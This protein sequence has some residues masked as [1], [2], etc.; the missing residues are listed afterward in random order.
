MRNHRLAT[1][2]VAAAM[3]TASSLAVASPAHAGIAIFELENV[4]IHECLQ[5]TGGSSGLGV[6]IA[7]YPCDGS[8]AQQWTISGIHLVNRSSGLCLD[9]RGGAVEYTAVEQWTC[10]WISNENWNFGTGEELVSGVSNTYSYCVDTV[11]NAIYVGTFLDRCEN[12]PWQWWA[13]LRPAA[14][15]G[16]RAPS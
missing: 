7:T 2:V 6:A 9:A 11:V 5:P 1:L 15:P 14:S 13:Q 12:E 10:D 4:Y 8:L 3:V 16:P